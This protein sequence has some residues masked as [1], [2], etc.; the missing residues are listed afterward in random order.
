MV[1]SERSGKAPAVQTLSI[2]MVALAIADPT[3]GLRIGRS[4]AASMASIKVLGGDFHSLGPGSFHFGVISI[5]PRDAA[6]GAPKSY[7]LKSDCTALQLVDERANVKVA[8]AAGWG[9]AGALVAGPA[10]LFAGAI[11]GG[12]GQKAV[13][14]ATFNDGKRVVAECDKATWAKMLAAMI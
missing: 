11:L 6:W 9:V 14:M 13:F 4:G 3:T 12:R 8:G 5:T 2:C 7:H 10:G 1:V